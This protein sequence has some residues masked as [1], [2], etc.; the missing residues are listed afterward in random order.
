MITRAT[1]L[2]AAGIL[3]AVQSLTSRISAE[4][5]PPARPPVGIPGDAVHFKGNWYRVYVEKGGWKRARER[6]VVLGGHLAIIPNAETQAFI[7]ELG[8]ELPLWLGATDEKT[9]GIWQWIDGT[10]LTFKA[11]EQGQPN[12]SPRENYLMMARNG[13]WHDSF[14]GEP[15][16]MGFICEWDRK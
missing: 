5:S 2:K 16:V 9:D 6:C 13:A 3:L 11:W 7:K 15:G 1:W 10:K 12:N 8:S 14:E 4:S